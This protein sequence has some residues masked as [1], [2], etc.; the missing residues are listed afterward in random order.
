MNVLVNRDSPLLAVGA[1]HLSDHKQKIPSVR[2]EH[3]LRHTENIVVICSRK[4]LICRH[5]HNRT[6]YV[7]IRNL[8]T[9]VQKGVFKVGRKMAQ[10]PR[11]HGFQGKE[12]RLRRIQRRFGSIHLCR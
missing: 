3:F 2:P 12:V 8:L 11:K 7:S 1:S 4:A 5:A 9:T 10:N 6:L